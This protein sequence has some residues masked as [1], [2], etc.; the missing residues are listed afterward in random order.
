MIISI[1]FYAH[2]CGKKICRE[3]CSRRTR[4]GIVQRKLPASGAQVGEITFLPDDCPDDTTILY[5]F[6]QNQFQSLHIFQ[7]LLYPKKNIAQNYHV[8]NC[9]P[10]SIALWDQ[11]SSTL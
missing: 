8:Q 1:P 5:L 11:L 9:K 3:S 10:L 2:R 7:R 4:R 6:Q